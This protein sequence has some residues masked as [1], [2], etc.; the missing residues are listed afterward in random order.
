MTFFKFIIQKTCNMCHD[1]MS[2]FKGW[3]YFSWIY[4]I[5]KLFNDWNL[6]KY[7]KIRFISISYWGPWNIGI[8]NFN[9]SI[10]CK[11]IFFTFKIFWRAFDLSIGK[12]EFIISCHFLIG[13]IFYHVRSWDQFL[14]ALFVFLNCSFQGI[15]IIRLNIIK[16]ILPYKN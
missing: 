12:T 13:Q 15:F 1:I 7:C 14:L 2:N 16:F 4:W 11:N 5:I 10:L 6:N 9:I 8:L 3:W